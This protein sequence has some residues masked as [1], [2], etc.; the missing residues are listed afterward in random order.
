M[1]LLDQF[2]TAFAKDRKKSIACF[3]DGPN[4]LRKELGV[5]LDTLEARAA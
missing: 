3:V 5:D 4:I 1:S 2:K